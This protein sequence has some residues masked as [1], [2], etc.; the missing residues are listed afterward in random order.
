MYC[1]LRP[2]SYVCYLC[3]FL[4]FIVTHCELVPTTRKVITLIVNPNKAIIEF[5]ITVSRIEEILMTSNEL[6]N[7]NAIK[8]VCGYL[9][10]SNNSPEKTD[11]YS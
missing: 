4:L 7:L 2:G 8:S 11:V 6:E 10:I 1:V 5:A 9:P 3:T